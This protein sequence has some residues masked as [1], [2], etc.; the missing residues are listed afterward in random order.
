MDGLAGDIAALLRGQEQ[1]RG[2]Y[3]LRNTHAT[4]RHQRLGSGRNLR[5]RFLA[6]GIEQ[7]GSFDK[8]GHDGVVAHTGHLDNKERLR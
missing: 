2:R 6:I 5:S 1:Y 7:D 8:A 3:V 4:R